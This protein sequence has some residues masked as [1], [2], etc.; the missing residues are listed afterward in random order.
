MPI[1]TA[2]DA[3]HSVFSPDEGGFRGDKTIWEDPLAAL[4]QAA[5]RFPS[6]GNYAGPG[7]KYDDYLNAR[8]AKDPKY[9]PA[10]DPAL[11]AEKT[12]VDGIDA[13]ARKHDFAYYRD[14]GHGASE[15]NMLSWQG[16]QNTRNA[17][18][19]LQKDAE[20][21][22][23]RP[24]LGK[25]GKPIA[26]SDGTRDYVDGMA[27]FFGGRADG[28][29]IARALGKGKM[30]VFDAAGAAVNDIGGAYD[31]HG[32]LGAAAETLGLANVAVAGLWDWMAS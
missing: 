12:T 23:L 28:V 5:G 32:G 27:G 6:Y 30:D 14:N 2:G 13:A 29:D 31:K 21:E 10:T 4:K 3:G 19:E 20:K 24:S 22:M 15:T 26:Y 25:D 8:W 9:D 11:S 1:K 18:R 7:N 17:D 16:L